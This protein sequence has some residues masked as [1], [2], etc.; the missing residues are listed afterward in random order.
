MENLF[1][2]KKYNGR[3]YK[4]FYNFMDLVYHVDQIIKP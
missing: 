2:W 3:F 4:F 1:F